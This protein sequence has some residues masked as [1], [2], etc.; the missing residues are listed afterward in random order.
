MDV[1][2]ISKAGERQQNEDSIGE[3]CIRERSAFIVCDGLGG[4]DKGEIASALAV[5]TAKEVFQKEAS[6]EEFFA[7]HCLK[8][9]FEECEKQILYYQKANVK[10]AE[11]KTTMTMLIFDR[12]FFQWAHIGD[13]RL[14]LFEKGR[15]KYH[16]KDHSV[17]QMLA[18]AGRIKEAE[19]RFHE[20]RSR[21]LHVLG[22]GEI[23]LRY[24]VSEKVKAGNHLS[25]LMCTDGFWEWITEKRMAQIL[26]RSS[27]AGEWLSMMEKEV[28]ENGCGKGMDNYSAIAIFEDDV[29]RRI[30]WLSA[31]L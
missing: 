14:Y 20:D 4:H 5:K 19:I 11:M 13:T 12:G 6:E 21:L 22:S 1:S 31:L 3:V 24:T 18:D 16:T 27:H 25:I 23:P 9:C 28:L 30:G 29:R 17:P 8:H 10:T 7:E 26:R 2:S 15:M